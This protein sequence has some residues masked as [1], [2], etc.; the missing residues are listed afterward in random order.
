MIIFYQVISLFFWWWVYSSNL[1]LQFHKRGS[2]ETEE[3]V[4]KIEASDQD[5][6][7]ES[8]QY[9]SSSKNWILHFP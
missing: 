3:S 9:G 4:I 6:L 8:P 5:I 2:K 1:V 7:T